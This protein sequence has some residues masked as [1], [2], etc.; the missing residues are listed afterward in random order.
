MLVA[1]GLSP[2]HKLGQNFLHDHNILAKLIDAA[3]ISTGDV[4]LEIGPGTG[5]LTETLVDR[6]CDVIACEL[7]AGLAGLIEERLGTTI[8]L[9]RGDC[10]T[11][12]RLNPDLLSAIDGRPFKLVA[13]LPYQ[14]ASPLM[15][16]LFTNCKNCEGQFVTIQYEVAQRLLAAVD[17]KDWG[18]LSILV[19]RLAD[20]ELITK[21]PP[22][23]FWPQPK[24]VSACVALSPKK[25]SSDIDDDEFATFVTSLFAKRRKQIG[26]I[27]GRGTVLPEDISP[28]ARPST[29]TI[30][31]LERL[32]KK[33]SS[34]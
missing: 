34:C 23:C 28:D 19:Q 27:L 22:T 18:V 1:R 20:V 11:K 31:Q 15:V 7:D 6:G 17:S 30:K 33:V 16:E 21:A 32:F 8:T 26:T 2:R 5:T 10:M 9:V 29:F 12:R 4:V 25:E 24:V 14:V 13:N 3:E